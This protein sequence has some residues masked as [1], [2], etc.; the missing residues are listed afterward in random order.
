VE[1]QPTIELKRPHMTNVRRK[2]AEYNEIFTKFNGRDKIDPQN[3]D[4]YKILSNSTARGVFIYLLDW[5]L[6]RSTIREILRNI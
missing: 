5:I 4:L 2:L 3:A 1:K 6:E